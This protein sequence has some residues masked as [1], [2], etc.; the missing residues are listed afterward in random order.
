MSF[1]FSVSHS[2]LRTDLA[3][4]FTKLAKGKITLAVSILAPIQ[5]GRLYEALPKCF[6]CYIFFVK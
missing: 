1:S 2:I 5:N 4:I 3:S 6:K